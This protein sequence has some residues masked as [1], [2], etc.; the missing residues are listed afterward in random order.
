MADYHYQ[1]QQVGSGRG[2]FSGRGGAAAG[3]NRPH[4][5]PSPLWLPPPSVAEGSEQRVF[6]ST[7]ATARYSSAGGGTQQH[8]YHAAATAAQ[9]QHSHRPHTNNLAQSYQQQQHNHHLHHP[10][11]HHLQQ[12]QLH[13]QQQQQQASPHHQQHPIGGGGGVVGYAHLPPAV[14][15]GSFV[16]SSSSSGTLLERGWFELQ[17]LA[18]HLPSAATPAAMV[19][20]SLFDTEEELLW[21]GLDNGRIVSYLVTPQLSKYSCFKTAAATVAGEGGVRQLLNGAEGITAVTAD[22]LYHYSTGGCLRFHFHSPEKGLNDLRCGLYTN[23]SR[24]ELLLAGERPLLHLLDMTTGTLLKQV[25]IDSDDVGTAL[26]F[27]CLGR[28]RLLCCGGLGGQLSLLDPRSFRLE[29]RFDSHSCG[30]MSLDVKGDLVATCGWTKRAGQS[31]PTSDPMVKIYDLRTMRPLPPVAFPPGAFQVKFHPKFSSSLF[32]VSQGGQLQICEAQG[33]QTNIQMYQVDCGGDAVLTIDLSS[34]GELAVFGDSG[35]YIHLWADRQDMQVNSYSRATA[36]PELPVPR[37]LPASFYDD[38]MS[39]STSIF[40]ELNE[41]LLS[42]WPPAM[43]FDVGL[44]SAK[45]PTQVMNNIKKLGRLHYAPNPR[46][47]QNSQPSEHPS[48][49]PPTCSSVT[50]S[51]RGTGV[52]APPKH[53]RRVEVKYYKLGMEGFN[54]EYYNRTKFGGLENVYANAYTHACLQTFYFIPQLRMHMLNHVCREEF[55]L[56]CEL[57]FLFHMLDICE[58]KS[59][60]ASNFLRT[61]RHMPS[62]SDLFEP[63]TVAATSDTVRLGRLIQRF[64]A[65]LLEQLQKESLR[66]PLLSSTTWGDSS[67]HPPLID[68]LFGSTF[69]VHNCCLSC[70][71]VTISQVCSVTLD[72]MLPP[73]QEEN[74]TPHF[75]DPVATFCRALEH[76]I[77]KAYRQQLW[78][79]RCALTQDH[80]CQMWLQD[81]PNVLCLNFPL[82]PNVVSFWR[83]LVNRQEA[84]SS[85]SWFPLRFYLVK[86]EQGITVREESSLTEDGN[87]LAVYELSATIAHIY[88]DLESNPRKRE[89]LVSHIKIPAS[90]SSDQRSEWYLFNDFSITTIPVEE[91]LQYNTVWKLPCLLYYTRLD[92]VERFPVPHRFNQIT[93]DV[94]FLDHPFQHNSINSPPRSRAL[95]Q[96]TI[97]HC[98]DLLALDA[99]FV[100]LQTEE[101]YLRSD[102]KRMIVKPGTFSLA[103]VSVL[104]DHA[105][106]SDGDSNAPTQIEQKDHSQTSEPD[107]FIDDYIVTY[108]PIAAY[109]TRFSG[110]VPGDLDPAVSPHHVTTLK[111]AYLKLRFLVDT[112]CIFVGH[113]LQKDFRIINIMVPPSQVRDTV[114][115]FYLER[116]RKLSLRFLASHLLNTQIQTKTHCSTEDAHTALRLYRLY[117]SLATT[118]RLD[119]TLQNLYHI[120]R[121]SNWQLKEAGTMVEEDP[122]GL[123]EEGEVTNSVT[124]QERGGAQDDDDDD[125]EDDD[126]RSSSP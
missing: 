43:D 58:G 87:I 46:K 32:V 82:G 79:D 96:Q 86:N 12:Q 22:R 47:T 80:L 106:V 11:H 26:G 38:Q 50:Q 61:F 69:S 116:Q 72:L 36:L 60:H 2:L 25:T 56:S 111:D 19:T 89:H 67:R 84:T 93:S 5:T 63:T 101:T 104:R 41:Q 107:V 51:S 91:V 123:N 122:Y 49:Q 115:L 124:A 120:G 1:Q 45:I 74:T 99:E 108:E 81:A 62:T 33:E 7:N 118:G 30:I 94:F 48:Q 9:Q 15:T 71:Y 24:T 13:Y 103:R 28:S 31:Y 29:H 39:L 16:G 64:N 34:T 85:P 20:A 44:K 88:N 100:S 6:H 119:D 68:Q 98:G 113:G 40:P 77:H 121:I 3:S 75:H 53:Y 18:E 70:N 105:P 92:S 90:Y 4:S 23:S 112:G 57:G 110:I 35:G 14:A 97:P 27:S 83:D 55:C 65:F 59:C 117:Q 10:L 126:G 42:D 73:A 109:L 78:C 37:H 76:S 95:T 66:A 21:T 125:I 102:G 52:M 8:L 54:F 17:S 114:D